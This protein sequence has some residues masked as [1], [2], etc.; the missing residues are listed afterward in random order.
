[1]L[2]LTAHGDGY[3]QLLPIRGATRC[4]IK[5]CDLAKG[6]ETDA[7]ARTV[8]IHLSRRDPDFLHQLSTSSSCRPAARPSW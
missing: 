7:T 1:M 6:I 2:A 4:S 8:T 3:F 5:R